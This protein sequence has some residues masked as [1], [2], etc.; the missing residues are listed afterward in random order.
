MAP[1]PVDRDRD[2]SLPDGST[3]ASAELVRGDVVVLGRLGIL[4][5]GS[6]VVI[7]RRRHPHPI[8]THAARRDH[9][10][11]A[12]GVHPKIESGN[13]VSVVFCGNY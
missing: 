6:S 1:R 5:L 9:M 12:R 10:A 13:V 4:A 7:S 8:A 2:T 11:V 3:E